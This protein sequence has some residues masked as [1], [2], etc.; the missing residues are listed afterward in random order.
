[1]PK[2]VT[3]TLIGLLLGLALILGLPYLVRAS[4]V[5]LAGVLGLIVLTFLG[6]AFGQAIDAR[7]RLR[8]I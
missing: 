2:V 5:T 3:G 1:M 4:W 6:M 7:D 8:D